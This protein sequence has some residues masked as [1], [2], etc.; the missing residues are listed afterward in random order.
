MRAVRELALAEIRRKIRK[1][2]GK[3]LFQDQI[4]P[5]RVER[6]K[7]GRVGNKGIVS[8]CV[9]LDVPRGV[10]PSSELFRDL[11]DGKVQFG[12]ELI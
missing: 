6:G 11:A 8:Q 10:P 7:A 3:L 1:R 9:Q 4:H 2:L 12:A 5:L